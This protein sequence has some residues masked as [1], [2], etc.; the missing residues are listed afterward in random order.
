[1]FKKLLNKKKTPKHSLIQYIEK[2]EVT[3]I[4]DI[5]E[6]KYKLEEAIETLRKVSLHLN[7]KSFTK[8]E[9]NIKHLLKALISMHPFEKHIKSS[10]NHLTPLFVRLIDTIKLQRDVL[11]EQICEIRRGELMKLVEETGRDIRSKKVLYGIEAELARLNHRL[12]EKMHYEDVFEIR[13]IKEILR[14]VF[15]VL[16]RLDQK[17]TEYLNRMKLAAEL[18]KAERYHKAI[19]IFGKCAGFLDDLIRALETAEKISSAI[20]LFNKRNLALNIADRHGK[21]ILHK[22]AV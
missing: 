10:I 3:T 12:E 5:K 2:L 21:K 17:E 7:K 9:T 22:Y 20:K 6:L 1:M 11:I 4:K 13:E 14:I 16:K 15:P 18:I 19:Q 8:D